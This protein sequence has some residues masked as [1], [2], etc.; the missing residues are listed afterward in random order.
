MENHSESS[1]TR[2]SVGSAYAYF[3]AFVVLYFTFPYLMRFS[4]HVVFAMGDNAVL[5]NSMLGRLLILLIVNLGMFT[6]VWST[7]GLVRLLLLKTTPG[8]EQS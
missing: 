7:I 1:L 5:A 8:E 2:R 4:I 6:I 3:A